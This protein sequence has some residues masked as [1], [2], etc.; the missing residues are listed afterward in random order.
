MDDQNKPRS[1]PISDAD[2]LRF[3]PSD[4]TGQHSDMASLTMDLMNMLASGCADL[5]NSSPGARRPQGDTLLKLA[6]EAE[7][8]MC[9]IC[10][11]R[12]LRQ[13]RPDTW[14]CRD[15]RCNTRFR[16]DADGMIIAEE[17]PSWFSEALRA[18]GAF[19]RAATIVEDDR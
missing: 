3:H 16:R 6:R 15:R 7:F 8:G 2:L 1:Q 11:R 14:D 4:A 13:V 17:R 18:L 5:R 10:E 12:L 19:L 9:P